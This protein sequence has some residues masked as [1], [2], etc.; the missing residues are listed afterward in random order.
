MNKNKLKL[1]GFVMILLV[2]MPVKSKAE[3][4]K[5]D[6][7]NLVIAREKMIG[8]MMAKGERSYFRISRLNYMDHE[9]QAYQKAITEGA[10]HRLRKVPGWQHR[11]ALFR[12]P[13]KARIGAA[14]L[15]F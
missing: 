9:S 7:T 6:F 12:W 11:E 8:E 5:T 15:R 14:G 2:V 1:L 13:L 10:G 3:Q 4:L